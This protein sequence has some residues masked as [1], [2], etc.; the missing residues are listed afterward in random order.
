M[1]S[2]TS[3]QVNVPMQLVKFLEVEAS[4]LNLKPVPPKYML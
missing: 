1:S 4:L 2:Y 3:W